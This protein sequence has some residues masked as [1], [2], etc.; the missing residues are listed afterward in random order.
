MDAVLRSDLGTVLEWAG[1]GRE[2]TTTDIPM[3]EM[4]VSPGA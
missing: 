4:W 2:N 1:N 3:P